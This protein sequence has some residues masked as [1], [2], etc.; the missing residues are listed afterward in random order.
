MEATYCACLVA[1]LEGQR[2]TPLLEEP[3]LAPTLS[4]LDLR[5]QKLE[6]SSH[7]LL[8]PPP[9]TPLTWTSLVW[10]VTR[11]AAHTQR[12]TLVPLAAAE[13]PLP[14]STELLEKIVAG[15]NARN[16][17]TVPVRDKSPSDK[18]VICD[19]KVVDDE[20]TICGDK[21]VCDEKRLNVVR[22][23]LC[24]ALGVN[25]KKIINV[26]YDLSD[27]CKL[28][29]RISLELEKDRPFDI[30]IPRGPPRPQIT[31]VHRR[32][33]CKCHRKRGPSFG[34]KVGA[35]FGRL[36]FWRRRDDDSDSDSDSSSCSTDSSSGSSSF[37]R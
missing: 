9:C 12:H 7:I 31:N 2:R 32:Y 10:R 24:Y 25:D 3:L 18:S 29:M 22:Q 14:P 20:K 33:V 4:A 8:A 23:S 15:I 16:P 19:D 34:R 35:F 17:G 1:N 37:C 5:I 30:W 6:S 36:A 28:A 11:V 26:P 27:T 21:D 13:A